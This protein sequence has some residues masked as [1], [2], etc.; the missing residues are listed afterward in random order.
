MKFMSN[1]RKETVSF[2]SLLS[3]NAKLEKTVSSFGVDAKILGLPLA[4]S[5]LSGRNVCA[6][7]S[8][9]C[10]ASCVGSE[11]G[12]KVMPN[13]RQAM[14]ARTLFF[15]EHQRSFFSLL[16]TELES[17]K[18]SA[19]LEGSELF[20]RP[21]E[22]S[23]IPWERFADMPWIAKAYD[24][25]AIHS[26]AIASLTWNLD[27]QLTFSVKETTP[28]ETVRDVLD[29]GGNVAIVVDTTYNP[30]QRKFGV[31]PGKVSIG[32][33]F[34]ETV[35]GDVHDLRRREIDGQG[36]VVLLRLKG[37]NKAREFARR[38]GFARSIPDFG[39]SDTL[40]RC[41][42]GGVLCA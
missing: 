31:L 40:Q 14:I 20:F 4:P 33:E 7:A 12:R 15:F 16:R 28:W 39:V 5:R 26:R 18:L 13:V 17:A 2:S 29:N 3:S 11:S 22:A 8:T 42:M 1:V 21:N 30:Q 9:A 23:D 24:Y 10:V 37:T 34:Y 27:Y 19:E 32:K 36:K 35:D 38:L 6:H 25:T 41:D